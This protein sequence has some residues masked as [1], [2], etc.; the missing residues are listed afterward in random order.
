MISGISQAVSD[1]TKESAEKIT[2]EV[3]KT[4]SPKLPEVMDILSKE[5]LPKELSEMA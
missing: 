5:I 4:V 1:F 3:F 2:L